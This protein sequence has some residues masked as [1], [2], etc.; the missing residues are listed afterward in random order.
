MKPEWLRF[1]DAWMDM[2]LVERN[3][4]SLTLEAYR[5]DLE[6]LAPHSPSP[7]EI[8]PEELR[9]ALS[10]ADKRGLKARS[11]ARLLSS[12]RSFFRFLL[13]E[14]ERKDSPVDWIDSPRLPATLP[15]VLQPGEIET[16]ID[17]AGRSRSFPLR[18]AALLELA[19]G[20]GLRASET[21][22]LPLADLFLEEDLLRVT[23][24]GSKQRWLPL[25]RMARISLENYLKKERPQLAKPDSPPRVFLNYRGSTLSRVG[26]WK[27][28]KEI[29][30]EAGLGTRVRP[31]SLRHSFATH[32]LE[33]GADLRSVQEML[34]HASI[35][36]TQIY[37]Q[38]DRIYLREV[39]RSFHPRAGDF[40]EKSEELHPDREKSFD[41]T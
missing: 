23:G 29:S 34:G 38:V 18:N 3:L 8:G 20:A 41:E 26:W 16:L 31:H 22:D 5:R 35:A 36:T 11:R 25:G 37:T 28:L 27:I 39:H 19:Y 40:S 6:L 10:E 12:W 7:L 33:G 9:E 17:V 14:G 2:L 15:D 1:C 4:S 13:R 32:L 21:V 30:R 24:K